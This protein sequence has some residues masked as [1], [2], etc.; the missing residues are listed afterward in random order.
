M[1]ISHRSLYLQAR[2]EILKLI[3]EQFEP[4]Q[5]IPPEQKLSN[6]LGVSRNTI[7]E[8]IKTLEQEGVL[9]SRQGV[10]TFVIASKK[11]LETTITTLESSTNI[12]KSHG[13]QPGTKNVKSDVIQASA[14]VKSKL[15]LEENDNH[16][17]YI[18]RVRTADGEPVVY[19]EDYILYKGGMENEYREKYYESL[20]EF[21]EKYDM[22][23]SFSIC[24]IK[25]V[26]SNEKIESKLDLK[27]KQA[28][29]LLKQ[30]H[31]SNTGIPV[32]YSESY[33]LS[34]KLEFNVVRKR[35]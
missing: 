19:V 12:I 18:E 9:F 6:Q 16:V 11:N 21:L 33:Y 10:G 4:M 29:L 14:K 24:T 28:L 31:Y 1:K 20:L 34:D 25:A 3:K 2:D 8:A 35:G 13:Y 5:K 32:L 30:I 26:I 27:E 15:T 7:R 23:V 17:F 22:K